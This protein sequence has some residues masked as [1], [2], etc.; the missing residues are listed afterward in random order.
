M[1]GPNDETEGING[2]V[3][4]SEKTSTEEKTLYSVLHRMIAMILAPDD[5]S[6]STPVM[7]RIKTSL[8]ENVPRLKDASRNT[9]REIMLW[10][11]RGSSLRALLVIAVGTI[12]LLTLTG[13]LVFMLFFLAAT[14]NAIVVSL[15]ISLAAAGGFL[16]LFLAC[17]TAIYIGALSVAVFVI[18]TAT[19][20][21]IVAVSIA[22]GWI[23]FLWTVW[24]LT[25]KS[26]GV[27]KHSL[28]VTGSAI[29][30]YSSSRHVQRNH[31]LNK[32][33]E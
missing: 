22:T 8:S 25:K 16:A 10:T 31:E 17:L 14:V 18:S 19:I 4:G 7:Q 23:G 15:L 30:A 13:L 11:R 9:G 12:A 32:V 26:M 5:S 20:S 27:A 3:G 24:L 33:T 6:A 28:H 21:A 29:S 1:D 2:G